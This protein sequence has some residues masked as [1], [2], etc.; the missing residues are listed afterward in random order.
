MEGMEVTAAMEGPQLAVT[1]ERAAMAGP[2]VLDSKF[3]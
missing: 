3:G 2:E 1:A